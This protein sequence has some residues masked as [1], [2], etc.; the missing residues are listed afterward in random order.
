MIF[1]IKMDGQFTRKAHYVAVGHTTNLPY[2]ITYS[3][4]V[5]RDSAR[6]SFTLAALNN[7][8]IRSTYIGNTHLNGKCQEKIWTVAGT[9]FGNEKG[10]VMLV[11][12]A[13]YGLKSSGSAWRQMLAQ[14]LGYV[15]YN[16][17]PDVW[18]KSVTKP[19]GAEYYAYYLV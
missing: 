5:S 15:S 9:E 12:R 18:R 6:I 16:A 14:T 13:L 1:D 7:A 8:E 4:V 3:S 17:D 19:Y 2:S 10:K 11:L